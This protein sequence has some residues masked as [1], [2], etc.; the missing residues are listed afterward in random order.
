MG[1][2][3]RVKAKKIVNFELLE[4]NCE[5]LEELT[6]TMG[7][8]LTVSGFERNRQNIVNAYKIDS[9]NGERLTVTKGGRLTVS[10]GE[11]LTVTM[12][13]RLAVTMGER[14]TVTM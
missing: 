14:L 11:R 12:G 5:W 2:R 10:M 8:I 3:L 6:A 7:E 1:E 13:E 9:N 4:V